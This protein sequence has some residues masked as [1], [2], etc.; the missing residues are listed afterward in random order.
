MTVGPARQGR[1]G[2]TAAALRV[3]AWCAAITVAV[4]CGYLLIGGMALAAVPDPVSATLAAGTVV[5]VVVITARRLRPGWFAFNPQPR[6]REKT[7][8]RAFVASALAALLLAFL[9]GQVA[10]AVLYGEY[11][12]SGFD[13]HEQAVQSSSPGMALLL[14]LL[15]APVAEEALFRGL[16]YPLLRR[17]AGLVVSMTVTAALFAL[18]H[19][20]LVQAAATLPLDL[21]LALIAERTRA[22][23]PAALAHAGYNLAAALVPPAV[24]QALTPAPCVILL[25]AAAG[26][27]VVRLAGLV[28]ASSGDVAGC[29]E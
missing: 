27:G 20:N 7:G 1:S 8:A 2:T 22:F 4:P 9:A 29:R 17:R 6:P 18:M 26:C 11:G 25:L 10:A 28:Q 24:I 21:V 12:S 5:A 14:S 15:V 16:L 19:G 3:V 13:R 23:G